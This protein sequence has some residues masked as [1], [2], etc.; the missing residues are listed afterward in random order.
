MND[1]YMNEAIKEALKADNINEIPVGAV[2][3]NKDGKIIGKGH[4]NREQNKLSISHAEVNAIIDANKKM[5]N[6]RLSDCVMYVTLEPCEMCKCIIKES[7][8][9]EVYYSS[10]N[11][12]NSNSINTKYLKLN[13]QILN[14]KTNNIINDSFKKI[15]NK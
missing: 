1:Y 11:F 2:I 15:R 4:N 3:V 12:K 10:D 5:N 8:I 13:D 9:K 14:D 6:W 7:R